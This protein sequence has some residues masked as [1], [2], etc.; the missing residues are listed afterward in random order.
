MTIVT[1]LTIPGSKARAI[2]PCRETQPLREHSCDITLPE[3]TI[4][5]FTALASQLL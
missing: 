4:V 1:I 2:P 5:A 3:N